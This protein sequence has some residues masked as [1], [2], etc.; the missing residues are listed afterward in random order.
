MNH[1]AD[2]P[3][4]NHA[5][6]VAREASRQ[7]AYDLHASRA[8]NFPPF[9]ALIHN[10]REALADIFE[11]FNETRRM[12]IAASPQFM[13][14]FLEQ[15]MA[16]RWRGH[17]QPFPFGFEAEI[18]RHADG[19]HAALTQLGDLVGPAFDLFAGGA[20]SIRPARCEG[21]AVSAAHLALPSY[22][23]PD[24]AGFF[25][26]AEFAFIAAGAGHHVETWRTLL[27]ALLRAEHIYMLTYGR[28]VNNAIPDDRQF[29]QY[30]PKYYCPIDPASVHAISYQHLTRF[31]A[32]DIAATKCAELAFPGNI[33]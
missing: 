1:R 25:Y 29:H 27:P 14:M 8:G 30:E 31:D 3:R 7:L 23:E 2:Q 24:G 20:L 17:P 33:P 32:L 21:S 18:R 19:M 26:W 22:P 5:P 16:A 10:D 9:W 6:P 15:R 12:L 11:F 28:L 4:P 13:P